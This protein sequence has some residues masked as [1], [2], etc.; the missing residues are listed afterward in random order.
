MTEVYTME[1]SELRDKEELLM[2][3]ADS[4]RKE[5][6]GRFLHLDDRLRCLSA[7]SLLKKHLPGYAE[8]RLKIGKDGKPFLPGG[9]AFS[10]STAEITWC[11]PGTQGLPA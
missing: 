8:E 7:G 2:E 4:R 11:W 5:K 9:P 10:L 3:S 6:A 1:L